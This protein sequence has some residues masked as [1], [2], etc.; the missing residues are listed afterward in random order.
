MN[1]YEFATTSIDT[2]LTNSVAIEIQA[3]NPR[4]CLPQLAIVALK[5][6]TSAL[7]S[8]RASSKSCNATGHCLQPC[9]KHKENYKHWKRKN[10]QEI[11][12]HLKHICVLTW[13]EVPHEHRL[14]AEIVACNTSQLI[15][16][17]LSL[18]FLC[19]T[20]SK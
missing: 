5:V 1:G 10:I 12:I 6:I 11:I 14:Q 16:S 7:L 4:C 18:H 20:I 15:V 8:F 3:L 13:I 9:P 2:H 17:D 19:F